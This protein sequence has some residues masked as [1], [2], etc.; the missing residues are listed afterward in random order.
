MLRVSLCFDFQNRKLNTSKAR[1]NY[2][3]HG[4]NTET[5]K[6]NGKHGKHGK[7]TDKRG[8]CPF[9]QRCSMFFFVFPIFSELCQIFKFS[10][11]SK[12]F[13]VFAVFGSKFFSKNG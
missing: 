13:E 2:G 4:K 1:K 7:S 6:N 11:F 10:R 12:V 3:K 5:M 8:L 9:F